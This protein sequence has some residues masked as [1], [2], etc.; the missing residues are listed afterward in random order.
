MD[1]NQHEEKYL[2]ES[3]KAGDKEAFGRLYDKYFQ[4]I[5]TYLRI[6]SGNAENAEDLTGMVFL[7]A[8]EH[9][10]G[11]RIRKK[12]IYFR[13]WLFRIAHNRLIDFYR[14]DKKEIA[15][16]EVSNQRVTQ[17][18]VEERIIKGETDSEMI[19]AIK[20]LDEISQQVIFGRFFSG[21]SHRETA[22]SL[23]ISEGNVRIIQYRALKKTK[24][25]F[26]GRKCLKSAGLR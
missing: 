16:D 23:G 25:N 22:F 13:A 15:L 7:K 11:F 21:L 18:R 5:F 8:W 3:A 20:T 24:G 19:R 14:A 12:D 6:R 17:E 10:P 4:Q 26:E 1:A 2:I 9:L